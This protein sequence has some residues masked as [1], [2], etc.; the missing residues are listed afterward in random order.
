MMPF[1]PVP[2]PPADAVEAIKYKIEDP[3]YFYKNSEAHLT[4]PCQFADFDIV[5]ESG[6]KEKSRAMKAAVMIPPDIW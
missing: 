1:S 4:I 2:A 6:E 3:I 5:Q